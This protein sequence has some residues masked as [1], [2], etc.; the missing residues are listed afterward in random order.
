F[1]VLFN[2]TDEKGAW[3]AL[4]YLVEQTDAF[5]RDSGK[6][7]RLGFSWGVVK[8]DDDKHQD[9]AG[10]LKAADNEMYQMKT[11]HKRAAG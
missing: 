7:W 1:V 2:D 9:L 5:N 10:L 3:I 4:Q 11:T 8:F 6:P